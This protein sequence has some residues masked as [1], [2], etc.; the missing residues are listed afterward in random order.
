MAGMEILVPP[1]NHHNDETGHCGAESPENAHMHTTHLFFQRLFKR[2]G[3]IV[4]LAHL[5]FLVISGI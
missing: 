4:S 3:F 5:F 1:M 2:L